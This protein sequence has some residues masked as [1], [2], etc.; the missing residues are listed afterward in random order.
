MKIK[1]IKDPYI[2]KERFD[3]I[4][5]IQ[6]KIDYDKWVE[7]IEM[8]L[9]YFT[10]L[11][12][13]D[14]GKRT[15]SSINKYPESFREGLLTSHNK[16][17]ALAEFNSKKGYYEVLLNFSGYGLITTTFMKKITENHLRILIDMSKY[18]DGYLLNNGKQI[19][20]NT[21]LDDLK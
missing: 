18:V 13:T 3:F 10:W 17:Q 1:N 9:D 15:L 5:K 8:N 12:N 20:D 6:N 4:N 16:R 14:K 21:I 7:F 11:E 19:I 2:A